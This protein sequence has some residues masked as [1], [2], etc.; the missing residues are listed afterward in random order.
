[1]LLQLLFY[2]PY[3]C[4]AVVVVMCGVSYVFVTTDLCWQCPVVFPSAAVL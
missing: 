3:V 2:Y 1:M 4:G